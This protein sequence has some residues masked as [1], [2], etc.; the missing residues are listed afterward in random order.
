[1]EQ[2]KPPA[3]P[4]TTPATATTP[5]INYSG[6][7]EKKIVSAI[8]GNA[9]AWTEAKIFA[10]KFSTERFFRAEFKVLL[11]NAI[12]TLQADGL[13]ENDI[14]NGTS[15]VRKYRALLGKIIGSGKL[16]EGK[17]LDALSVAGAMEI[18]KPPEA[19]SDADPAVKAAA[20]VRACGSKK[21]AIAA[22]K[23]LPD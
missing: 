9:N 7:L 12:R 19:D 20:L 15:A 17:E 13:S 18:V 3:K 5:T 14:S 16:P 1:M 11:G 10:S 22:I 6:D 23:A 2:L 4:A 21:A 8:R